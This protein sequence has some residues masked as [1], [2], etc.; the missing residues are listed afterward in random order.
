[1]K[2]GKVIGVVWASKKVKELN[3]CRLSVVQPISTRGENVGNPLVVADPKSIG[4]VGNRIIYVTS[5]D[6]AQASSDVAHTPSDAVDAPS[7]GADA[8][9]EGLLELAAE[10]VVAE[11]RVDPCEAAAVGKGM[12]EI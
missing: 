6:A 12:A 11:H 3:G 10:G 2:V 7:A 1:M 8:S 4:A 5:T 9:P